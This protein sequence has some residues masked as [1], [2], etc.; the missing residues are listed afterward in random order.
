MKMQTTKKLSLCVAC[1][2]TF[3]SGQHLVA[4]AATDGEAEKQSAKQPSVSSPATSEDALI[5]RV[6]A[7]VASY[8]P[9]A[10]VPDDGLRLSITVPRSTYAP[11]DLVGLS[12]VLEKIGGSP[13][14]LKGR[15]IPLVYRLNVL[16]PDG[17][18][19]PLSSKGEKAKSS[20]FLTGGNYGSTWTT[21]TFL[22]FG[23]SASDNFDMTQPG[24]YSLQ[25]S[26]EVPSLKDPKKMVTLSS[27]VVKITIAAPQADDEDAPED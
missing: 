24:E 25:V 27:N 9:V 5:A 11:S 15:S 8:K 16:R 4:Q 7:H 20:L 2:A 18:T 1:A 3:A 10:G 12:V 6:K 26:R 17:T 23:M 19:A 14:H 21:G 22:E 13:I